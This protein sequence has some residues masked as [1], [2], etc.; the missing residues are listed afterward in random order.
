[1]PIKPVSPILP[2]SS[3]NN[4]IV[5]WDGTGGKTLQNSGVTIDDSNNLTANNLVA[6]GC[7]EA[8]CGGYSGGYGGGSDYF[9]TGDGRYAYFCGGFFYYVS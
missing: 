3:S 8:S 7:I 9:Y 6:C 4:A 2:G 1:M 5:R